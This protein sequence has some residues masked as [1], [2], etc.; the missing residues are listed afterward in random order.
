MTKVLLLV[1]GHK[2]IINFIARI[3][4]V[5]PSLFRDGYYLNMILSSKIIQN[6]SWKISFV[7]NDETS[8]LLS[9]DIARRWPFSYISVKYS[10]MTLLLVIIDGMLLMLT[11]V[12]SLTE[13]WTNNNI[14]KTAWSFDVLS[15]QIIVVHQRRNQTWATYAV[16]VDDL[17]CNSEVLGASH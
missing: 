10:N 11:I 17:Y 4:V 13:Y 5:V 6:S 16:I 12:L 2:Q 9:D 14:L 3:I 8:L 7:V 1:A 15:I